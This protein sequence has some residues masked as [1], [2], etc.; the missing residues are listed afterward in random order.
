MYKDLADAVESFNEKGY[1]NI[2]E[3][4]YDCITCNSLEKEFTPD[5]LTLVESH[6]FE[7][8]NRTRQ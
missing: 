6:S 2:F 5:E 7:Q 4:E 1:T 8:G 3:L